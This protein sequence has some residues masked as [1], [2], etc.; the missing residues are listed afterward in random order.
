MIKQVKKGLVGEWRLLKVGQGVNV[1]AVMPIDSSIKRFLSFLVMVFLLL[2]RVLA[3]DAGYVGSRVCQSCHEGQFNAWQGSHHDLAMQR[4]N[5]NSV[6]GNF[7][8]AGFR[9]SKVTSTFYQK[10]GRY[11]V[12]T[13]GADGKLQDYEIKYTFGVYPL[14]QYL[15]ELDGGRVQALS[16]A[17]DARPQSE[18]AGG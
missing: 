6:L 11:R 9:H 13:D 4:A 17:W 1:T 14:Q 10:D 2:S 15:V 5:A 18:G 7:D 8:N 12:R 3:D 16:I